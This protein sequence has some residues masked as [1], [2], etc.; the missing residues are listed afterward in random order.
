MSDSEKQ[1]EGRYRVLSKEDLHSKTKS[2]SIF[3]QDGNAVPVTQIFD[4]NSASQQRNV[5][6]FIR[7]FY[8]GVSSPLLGQVHHTSH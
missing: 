3:D 6:V 2:L 4:R 5:I 8:C 1:S 7:H